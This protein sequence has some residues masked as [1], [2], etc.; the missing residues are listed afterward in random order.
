MKK[1]VKKIEQDTTVRLMPVIC[2]KIVSHVPSQNR[3]YVLFF[4]DGTRL[5]ISDIK[6]EGKLL[7]EG[8]EVYVYDN[9]LSG[10]E[11]SEQEVAKRKDQERKAER[12]M[13]ICAG[14]FIVMMTALLVML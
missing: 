6:C 11:L 9:I 14:I 5:T 12:T 4:T 10:K 7:K 3:A 8:D 13:L 1:I 2:G